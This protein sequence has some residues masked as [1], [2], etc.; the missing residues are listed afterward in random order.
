MYGTSENPVDAE[1]T[2]F[3]RTEKLYKLYKAQTPRLRKSQAHR[4]TDLSNVVDFHS[5]LESLKQGGVTPDGIFKYEC[6]GFNRPIF[7][8]KER[9][10]FYFI[11]GAL[12]DDEQA[13]WIRESLIS[14]PQPPNR[15]N[16]TEAYG[17]IFDL[18]DA[19]QNNKVLVEAKGTS[20]EVDPVVGHDKT[21][22]N[23]R[24]FLFF[25]YCMITDNDESCKSVTASVLLRKLRWS[26]L[27]LQFDWSKRNYDLSLP[28]KKI[29]DALCLVAKKMAVPAMPNGEEFQPE[30]AIVNYFGPSDMLG[31]HLDDM[32][33][34][35]SKPIVSISLGCKA[36]FLL[37][38]KSK[39]DIPISMFLRS[40][41]VVLMAGEARECFHG[42]PRIFAHSDQADNAALISQFSNEAD[43]CF[44]EYIRTSR[45]NINIRQVN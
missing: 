29:P 11:P 42:V 12:T 9:S 5:V 28:H 36:I 26:T 7:C 20:S 30:A 37:G 1:R 31:G 6:R 40:G 4:K 18:F 16:H 32:E 38:G 45:I 34:D 23:S 41:D 24:R 2:A 14:F 13:Y 3:R 25:E 35:W 22:L 39:E 43:L 17:P 15:T 27:G 44:R 19:V 8:F 10:G 33:K 21:N